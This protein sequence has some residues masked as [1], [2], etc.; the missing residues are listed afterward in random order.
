MTGRGGRDMR[1]DRSINHGCGPRALTPSNFIDW[2]SRRRRGFAPGRPASLPEPCQRRGRN[3]PRPRLLAPP[4]RCWRWFSR[5]RS[6]AL[7]FD[8]SCRVH[9]QLRICNAADCGPMRPENHKCLIFP[10]PKGIAGGFW[11]PARG[12]RMGL[13]KPLRRISPSRNELTPQPTCI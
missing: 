9:Q 5:A 4:S 1:W 12:L 7:H 8:S 3:Y 10:T 13:M 11:N 6:G 2:I